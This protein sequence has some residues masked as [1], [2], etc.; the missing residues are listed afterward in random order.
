M[1]LCVVC[2]ATAAA[3]EGSCVSQGRAYMFEGTL[4]GLRLAYQTFEDCDP[5]HSNDRELIFLHSLT[6]IIMWGVKDDGGNVD[7]ALEFAGQFGI[8]ITGDS[9]RQLVIE[10]PA[11]PAP[12]YGDYVMPAQTPDVNEMKHMIFDELLPGFFDFAYNTAAPE[13]ESVIA[14]LDRITETPGDRFSIEF[15]PDETRLKSNLEVDYGDVLV[16]KAALHFLKSQLEM[17][18]AYDIFTDANDT[19][20]EKYYGGA[21]NVEEDLLGRYPNLL[22]VLPTPGYPDDGGAL[23]AQAKQNLINGI[24]YYTSA[25]NYML[26]EDDPQNDDLLSIDSRLYGLKD[27]IDEKLAAIRRNLTAGEL[28]TQELGTA[29]TYI[30]MD[31]NL[32][33]RGTMTLEYDVFDVFESGFFDYVMPGDDWVTRWDVDRIEID[34]FDFVAELEVWYD[35]WGGGVLAGTITIDRSKISN[36]TFEYW[37]DYEGQIEK[38]SASR[39]TITTD[40]PQNVDLNP[41]YGGTDAYPSPV[42]PRDVLPEFDRWNMP[43]AGTFGKGLG[44]DATLGGIITTVTQQ[45]WQKNLNLQPDGLFYLEEV[46]YPWQKHI[47]DYETFVGIWMPNQLVFTD[48]QGDTMKNSESVHNVDIASLYMGY[49]D[50]RLYGSIFIHDFKQNDEG[51]TLYDLYFS[52]NHNRPDELSSIRL[53]IYIS[54]DWGDGDIYYKYTDDDGY[55]YWDYIDNFPVHVGPGGVD[56]SI[57]W[58]SIPDYLPGRFVTLNSSGYEYYTDTRDGERNQTSMQIGG[59]GI[60]SGTVTCDM[61]T[62]KGGPIIVQACTNPRDPEGSIVA[63]TVINQPGHYELDGV[64]LGWFGIVRAVMPCY[65]FNVSGINEWEVVKS[66]SVF[67]GGEETTNVDLS[68]GASETPCA[69]AGELFTGM[70]AGGILPVGEEIWYYIVAEA[71]EVMSLDFLDY[72]GDITVAIFDRCGGNMLMK[73][74]CWDG[75]EFNVQVGKAYYIRLKSEWEDTY[76][77]L[78][79]SHYGPAITNDRCDTALEIT[80]DVNYAGTTEGALCD[81]EKYEGENDKYDVWFKFTPLTSGIYDMNLA[82]GYWTVTV[83]EDCGGKAVLFTEVWPGNPGYLNA[84]MGTSYYIRIARL[85][86]EWG[87]YTLRVSYYGAPLTNDFCSNA[88]TIPAGVVTAGSTRGALNDDV[89]YRFTPSVTGL[90]DIS[91]TGS[92]YSVNVLDD[93]DGNDVLMGVGWPFYFKAE[94]GKSY[95]IGV[96]GENDNSGFTIQLTAG[97][98][99]PANDDRQDAEVIS[100]TGTYSGTTVRA[101]KDGESCCDGSSADVWYLFM[102]ECSGVF[103]V[104]FEDRDFSA[105]LTVLKPGYLGWTDELDEGACLGP[106][107]DSAA[108]FYVDTALPCYIRVAG[109]WNETGTFT[110]D[111]NEVYVRLFTSDLTGDNFIDFA[112]VAWLCNYWLSQCPQSYWCDGADLSGNK[113][114]E[115]EDFAI[116][117][118]KW[119]QT[120]P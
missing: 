92:Y 47:Y 23:L 74:W 30:I 3:D 38:L 79:V 4:S 99:G 100:A 70:P 113:E 18:T 118:N 59:V 65:E 53:N 117:A 16:L 24:D 97:A 95:L 6:R 44:N 49:D 111:I 40:N 85:W 69:Q 110:F 105:T 101:T 52:Y 20:I 48:P 58:E 50:D 88:V 83:Y 36:A 42:N 10:P 91:I 31:S 96:E 109:Y 66:V 43:K 112:D 46:L 72:E 1:I 54:G 75:V 80:A 78:I 102:P 87:P 104:K 27:K 115:F 13:V 98:A 103:K 33:V 68:L 60:I 35:F 116:L 107:D 26:S 11:Y 5:A 114:V 9:Y 81:V 67:A 108:Y 19:I 120:G 15:H 64:G 12:V 90:Y 34:G 63:S 7:S 93:C 56:F 57:P 45:F 77:S 61:T 8:T 22:K 41:I 25:I 106:W 62:Y 119:L 17:Q 84:V 32:I 82:S 37:G 21:L 28:I 51:E 89:W 2:A 94:T 14:E 73:G 39:S 71:N 86:D 76:Y 29:E 55:S